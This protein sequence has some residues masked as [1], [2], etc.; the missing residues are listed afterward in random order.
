MCSG[1]RSSIASG[2]WTATPATRTATCASANRTFYE[3]PDQEVE[4]S[5]QVVVAVDAWARELAQST[6]TGSTPTLFCTLDG[7]CTP[8]VELR[9]SRD[10]VSDPSGHPVVGRPESAE[11]WL[12]HNPDVAAIDG[13]QAHRLFLTICQFP[14]MRASWLAEVPEVPQERCPAT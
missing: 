13:R 8:A 10:L 11:V 5:A 1:G 4:P 7:N 9:P 3:D 6:L 12:Q 2:A 14:A